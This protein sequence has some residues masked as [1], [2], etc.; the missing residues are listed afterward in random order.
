MSLGQWRPGIEL[1]ERGI[2][3]LES[4]AVGVGWECA[5]GRSSCHNARLWRGD[6]AAIGKSA[7]SWSRASERV[8]DRYSW[9]TAE[10]YTAITELAANDPKSARRRAEKAIAKWTD[11][12][13][14]YQ[15]WLALKVHVWCDLYEARTEDAFRRLAS[16]YRVYER[17]GLERVL[18]M[19]LDALLLRATVALAQGPHVPSALA[20]AERDAKALEREDRPAGRGAAA[21]VRGGIAAA[22]GEATRARTE[23]AVAARE[24]GRADVLLHAAAASLAQAPRAP[25]EHEAHAAALA[26]FG[27]MQITSPERFLRVLVPLAR[28]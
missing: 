13:F 19:R 24:L 9:V 21:L 7:P 2:E 20:E 11:K 8:G 14:H 12:G 4:R 3:T 1:M 10:L 15:H 27:R 6:L 17:S 18:L 28:T 23:Y 25:D 16:A 5:T 22:R 26:H